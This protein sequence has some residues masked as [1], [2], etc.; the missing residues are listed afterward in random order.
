MFGR[1]VNLL[2][3]KK[4]FMPTLSLVA[5]VRRVT[6]NIDPTVGF[7]TSPNHNP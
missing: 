6:R 4:T 5:S 1:L 3:W 2:N 7:C